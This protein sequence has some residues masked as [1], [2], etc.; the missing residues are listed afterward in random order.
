[1]I[2]ELSSLKK[3]DHERVSDVKSHL[4]LLIDGWNPE[5]RRKTSEL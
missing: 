1:M 3:K 4:N 2:Q 5:Q